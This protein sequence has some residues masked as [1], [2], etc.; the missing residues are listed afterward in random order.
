MN[1]NRMCKLLREK[2]YKDL[3]FGIIAFIFF[4]IAVIQSF[5][6]KNAIVP[7]GSTSG[8]IG[9][10]FYPQVFC[11]LGSALGLWL[12]VTNVIKIRQKKAGKAEVTEEPEKSRWGMVAVSI[13]LIIILVFLISTLG[14][15]VGS[16]LYLFIQIMVLTKR[17]KRTIKSTVMTMLISIGIPVLIYF[18]FR[19]IFDIML[20]LGIFK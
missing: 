13:A 15:I 5:Y 3:L 8:S 12:I 19:Y 9:A 14:S 2:E 1:F 4:G 7:G 6:F 10:E 17:E 16:A 11:S 18:P 20:P